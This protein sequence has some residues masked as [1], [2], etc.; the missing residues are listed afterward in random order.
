MYIVEEISYY[1][2]LY[3]GLT[4]FE[5]QF[6]IGN[7]NHLHCLLSTLL[8]ILFKINNNCEIEKAD[9]ITQVS[10]DFSTNR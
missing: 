6:V 3:L 1:L 8:L 4:K 7:L 9:I 10:K 2:L 5:P